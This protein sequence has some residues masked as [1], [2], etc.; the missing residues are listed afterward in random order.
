MR[1]SHKSTPTLIAESLRDDI[2]S[3][4]LAAGAALH[5]HELAD[6]FGVSRIPVREALRQLETDGTIRYVPSRG[7][8]V[9]EY[10]PDEVAER[11]EIRGQI[12][13]LALRLAM[14]HLTPELVRAAEREL[15][16]MRDET[17]PARWG[18]HHRAFHHVLY[19]AARRPRLLAII[20]SLYMSVTTLLG[21]GTFAAAMRAH[22]AEHA[23]I[24]DACRAGDA[25][26]GER[27]LRAH[28]RA[29]QER[30]LAPQIP[31]E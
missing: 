29:T 16:A 7:A 12:E 10:T 11:F 27:A 9:S 26:A 18:K 2:Q 21:P 14:P 19:E 13:P 28:L 25:K 24:L 15:I 31:A 30:A 20:E 4:R 3:G 5:Q 17:D 22:D 23:A 8:V 6:R 1:L